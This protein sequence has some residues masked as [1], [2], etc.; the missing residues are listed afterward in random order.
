MIFFFVALIG[1]LWLSESYLKFSVKN[2]PEKTI[3]KVKYVINRE[4]DVELSIW[5]SSTA[6]GNVNPSIIQDS[7]PLTMMNM[8]LDGTNI[9]QY[10]GL[11]REYLSYSQNSKYVIFVVD[12]HGGI[13]DRDKLYE[14]HKWVPFMKNQ[15]VYESF[16]DIDFEPTFK[17]KYIPFYSLFLYDKHTLNYWHNPFK[18][19][20]NT[21]KFEELGHFIVEGQTVEEHYKTQKI[22]P[23]K[24]KIGSR[25]LA[26]L[27]K[28]CN[29]TL[30]KKVKP[31]IAI[32]PCYYKGI[33]HIQ[34]VPE[35]LDSIYSIRDEND[36]I[37]VWDFAKS[38]ISYEASFF[39]DNIHMTKSGVREWSKLLGHKIKSL[40]SD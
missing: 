7:V 6:E 10:F 21:F 14:V 25:A 18:S 33:N 40:H 37:E 24:V 30:E 22:K 12:I 16:L 5:G 31:I 1:I 32:S 15:Y 3:E 34:N 26:K 39:R 20:R 28:A 17:T 4:L 36:L 11:I 8:G 35:V 27:K 23:L 38:P 13:S 29:L 19:K 2:H 9:D